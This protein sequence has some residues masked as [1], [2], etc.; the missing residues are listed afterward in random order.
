[1]LGDGIMGDFER[2]LVWE[3]QFVWHDSIVT[4]WPP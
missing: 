4:Q 3:R 2:Q 1:M